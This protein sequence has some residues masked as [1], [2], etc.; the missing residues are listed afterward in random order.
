MTKKELTERCR[1]ITRQY[2]INEKIDNAEHFAFLM[3]LFSRHSEWDMKRGCGI[4]S[5]TVK[6]DFYGNKYFYLNRVDGTGTDISFVHCISE[7]K[8]IAIIKQAC[9]YAVRNE[10]EAY[11]RKNVQYGVTTCPITGDVLTQD[12]THIDHYDLTFQQMFD[13]WIAGRSIDELFKKINKTDDN[14]LLTYFTCDLLISEF[15][16]FHNKH[17]KLRAVT[18][19]ANLSILRS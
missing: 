5:I 1:A 10:I 15:I 14:S 8:P 13:R 18:K 9:R 11:R 7:R 16:E 2:N 3:N 19:T 17:C 12:N 6:K 4:K